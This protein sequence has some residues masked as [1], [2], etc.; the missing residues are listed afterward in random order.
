M[1]VFQPGFQ[2]GQRGVQAELIGQQA[3]G[4]A[5][6]QRQV[7]GFAGVRLKLRPTSR[8]RSESRLVVSVSSDTT[9]AVCR[10][11]SQASSSAWVRI[12]V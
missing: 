10:R 3:A 12:S 1:R 8:A 7:G 11:A 6:H 4:I 9:G 5:V 2:R